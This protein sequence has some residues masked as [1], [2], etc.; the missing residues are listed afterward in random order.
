MSSPKTQLDDQKWRSRLD[1][2]IIQ[3]GSTSDEAIE[4]V[5]D[6]SKEI[7]KYTPESPPSVKQKRSRTIGIPSD[8]PLSSEAVLET[9][10]ITPRNMENRSL[11]NQGMDAVA[12]TLD[13][14]DKLYAD[15]MAKCMEENE[16]LRKENNRLSKENER[17]RTEIQQLRSN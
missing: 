7:E 1:G 17:L 8:L 14:L 10:F 9:S 11:R 16:K 4:K 6:A 5:E 2:D 12:V 15:Q 3:D 13:K